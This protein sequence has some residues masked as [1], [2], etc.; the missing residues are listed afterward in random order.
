MTGLNRED[1]GR[2]AGR[3][4]W[5]RTGFVGTTDNL[6]LVLQHPEHLSRIENAG[7]LRSGRWLVRGVSVSLR[8]GEIT[9]LIGPNGAGKST[10]AKLIIGILKPDEGAAWQKP[11]LRLAYVPQRLAID[12][13]LPLS[14]RRFMHLTGRITPKDARRA[15]IETE[16]AHLEDAQMQTLSGGEFQRVLLARAI[17]RQPQLLV[18]DEPVQ[19]V[20][21][22]G[23]AALYD[24]IRRIRDRHGCGILLI[25][26]NLHLVMA[27]TDHVI[28]LNGHMCCSGTP[29]SVAQSPEYKALFGARAAS[30]LAV[31][32]HDH[33][34]THLSDG[35]VQ[36]ADGTV[37]D[38]QPA[39]VISAAYDPKR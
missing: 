32:E 27:A 21:F 22:A 12:W 14:V 29:K 1:L 36:Y 4:R 16:A 20:D 18:L 9:T 28:C 6:G 10:T 34:H 3:Q 13:T 35:R 15:L 26:H 31:Y 11:T 30:A 19:G 33:D 8:A 38:G 25:S 2:P 24:L 23:E 17:A 39:D 37:S 5:A 7:V